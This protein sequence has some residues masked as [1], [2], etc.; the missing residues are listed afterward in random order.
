MTT[1]TVAPAAYLNGIDVTDWSITCNIN[2]GVQW[3]ATVPYWI[4]SPLGFA[5]QQYRLDIL[6]GRGYSYQS[7]PLMTTTAFNY[8]LDLANNS[9]STILSGWDVTT[10]KLSQSHQSQPTFKNAQAGSVIAAISKASG[11]SI[12]AP[13]LGFSIAEEDIKQS[14]WWDPLNRIAEVACSNWIIDS[15]GSLRLVPVRWFSDACYFEPEKL[16]YIY[17]QSKQITGFV[18]VKATSHYQAGVLPSRYYDFT[19][20]GFKVQELRVP[21]TLPIAVDRSTLGGVQLV[22][23][24]TADPTSPTSGAQLTAFWPLGGISGGQVGLPPVVV[25]LTAKFFTCSV[26]DATGLFA[27]LPLTAKLEISGS[28]PSN[29]AGAGLPGVD[30]AFT[31]TVGVVKGLAARPGPVRNEPLYPS[32]AYVL[33]HSADLLY[34]AN[35]Q[36]H[37]VTAS[38]PIDCSAI[39]GSKFLPICE[40]AI[41]ASRVESVTH[42]GNSSSATTSVSAFVL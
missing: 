35:K 15:S 7:P 10:W 37:K 16:S 22:G 23:F 26:A 19:S 21:L 8:E 18:V 24:W 32:K 13:G 17:D 28:T 20:P 42:S 5:N 40:H 1:K 39:L 25:G 38:G 33:A 6:D 27:G 11:V 14:N 4:G 31:T 36:F 12:I 2:G 30:L 29:T 9:E 3:S 41:P 34:E